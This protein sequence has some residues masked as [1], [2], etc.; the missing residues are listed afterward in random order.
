MI[1]LFFGGEKF[2]T[3]FGNDFGNIDL[4]ANLQET[5]DWSNDVTQ[6]PVENGSDITD[7]VI[8][9]PDRITIRGFISDSP[10]R[11]IVGNTVAIINALSGEQS[12]QR[13]KETFDLLEKLSKLKLP[14]IVTTKYKIYTDMIMTNVSIPRDRSTGEGLEFVAEFISIRT[15]GTQTVDV[16]DGISEK[17][18]AKATEALGNKA[19]PQKNRGTIQPENKTSSVLSGVFDSLFGGEGAASTNTAP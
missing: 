14:V 7:H 12:G 17:K 3:T 1:G 13:T 15:V 19:E 18:E 11:G 16:P 4:D 5:H 10:L 8:E 6:N 9:N 2:K